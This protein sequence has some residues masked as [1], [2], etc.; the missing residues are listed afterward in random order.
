MASASPGWV[1]LDGLR[2]QAEQGSK[3]HSSV[4]SASVPALAFFDDT[5]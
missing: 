4:P 5:M 2:K 1:V 3:Q